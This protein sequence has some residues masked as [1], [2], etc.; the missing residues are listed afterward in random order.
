MR[1]VI[2]ELIEIYTDIL[3]LEAMEVT[4]ITPIT[5]VRKVCGHIVIALLLKLNTERMLMTIDS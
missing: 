1:N 2:S 5:V 4:K 3:R